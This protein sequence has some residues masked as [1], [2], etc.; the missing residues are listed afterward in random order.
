MITNKQVEEFIE[1]WCN[2]YPDNIEFN[3]N[4]LKA[5]PKDVLKKMQ[6]FCKAHPNYTKDV[7]FAA[8]KLYVVNQQERDW[9]YTKMATYFI[10]KLGQPSVLES[11][12]EK[13]LA[14]KQNPKS[15]S[16]AF[17]LENTTDFI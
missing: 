4:K 10:S 13:I 17:P 8:T 6:K 16:E 14:T 7:I 2:I 9:E 5:K 3:G 1:Q 12:C 11:Y 15:I